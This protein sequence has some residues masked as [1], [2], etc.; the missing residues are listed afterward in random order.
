MR[1][2]WPFPIRNKG[3][4]DEG[5]IEKSSMVHFSTNTFVL[6]NNVGGSRRTTHYSCVC[7]IQE[8]DG[9]EYDTTGL[10]TTKLAKSNFFSVVNDQ[11]AISRNQLKA[12]VL[13]RIF[14]AD[15]RKELYGFQEV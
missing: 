1:I 9:G 10:R 12:L 4:G 2:F 14:E 5:S 7:G 6:I 11:F 15:R 3:C 13:D 8:V